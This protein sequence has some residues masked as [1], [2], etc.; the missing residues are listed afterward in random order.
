MRPSESELS[1]HNSHPPFSGR[2]ETLPFLRSIW[3][4]SASPH[5]RS[6][7]IDR[8][9][10]SVLTASCRRPLAPLLATSG[11]AATDKTRHRPRRE[12]IN[13]HPTR[14]R[15]QHHPG[16]LRQPRPEESSGPTQTY[17]DVTAEVYTPPTS[18]P[19]RQK[20]TDD[21]E[22]SREDPRDPLTLEPPAPIS[23]L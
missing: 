11:P 1:P 13:C 2:A 20:L 23:P 9:P 10:M 22:C 6:L 19:F 16:I 4:T 17:R 8:L 21:R 7:M 3:D 18:Q 5:R 12:N 15:Q 14:Q